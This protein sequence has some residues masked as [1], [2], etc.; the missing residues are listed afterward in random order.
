MIPALHVRP[1]NDLVKM[2]TDSW[3]MQQGKMSPLTRWLAED[4]IDALIESGVLI[5][6]ESGNDKP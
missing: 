1:R 4:A 5:T 2:I 3:E 6:K